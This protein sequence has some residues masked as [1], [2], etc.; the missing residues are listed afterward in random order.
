MDSD[1]SK[2]CML[3][4]SLSLLFAFHKEL[5]KWYV[6]ANPKLFQGQTA[7]RIFFGFIPD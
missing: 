5:N 6:V 7:V 4:H 1:Q 3:P 2:T